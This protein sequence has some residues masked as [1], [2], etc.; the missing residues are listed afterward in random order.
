MSREALVVR[1][2]T[3]DGAG[4]N[5]L[6]VVTDA[7]GLD[8]GGMQDIARELGYSETVFLE[9][10]D[11]DTPV[12]RIFTPGAELPFAGHP[13]VGAAWAMARAG[14][15]VG[16]LRCG[17]GDVAA[18]TSGVGAWI[19]PP[20]DQPVEPGTVDPGGWAEPL[21]SWDVLMPLRYHLLHLADA[22]AV[23]SLEVPEPPITEVMAWAWSEEPDQVIARFFAPG[24]GVPEDPATGSAAVALAAVLRHAGRASGD[25]RILQGDRMG[26]PST[27]ELAWGQSFVRVGGRVEFDHRRSL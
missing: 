24:V 19:E 27:I 11:G 26:S 25:L 2:F 15:P 16:A 23:A 3:R 20:F 4:G 18:G 21:E 22:R 13:L 8:G 1:V 14:R 5:H 7:A 10:W 6:G 9:S 17:I 12:V